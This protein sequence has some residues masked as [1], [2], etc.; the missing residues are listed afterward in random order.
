MS[1]FLTKIIHA[2]E[3]LSLG[4]GFFFSFTDFS[5]HFPVKKSF[6]WFS[7]MF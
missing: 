4:F 2:T 7:G 3:F 6:S 5:K 1:K